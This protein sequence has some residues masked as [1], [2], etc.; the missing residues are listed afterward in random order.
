MAFASQD[1]TEFKHKEPHISFEITYENQLRIIAEKR[2]NNI[3]PKCGK[4]KNTMVCIL[5]H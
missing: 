4:D 3:C 1:K 5:L 2:K